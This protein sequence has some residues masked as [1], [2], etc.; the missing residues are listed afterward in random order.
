MDDDLIRAITEMHIF[1]RDLALNISTG[2]SHSG[3]SSS[4]SRK[5]KTRSAAAAV[6]CRMFMFCAIMEIGWLKLRT[7][8]MND[9]ISPTVIDPFIAR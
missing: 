1:K 3:T 6:D 2:F 7:Y 9:W 8:V 4:S 5:A